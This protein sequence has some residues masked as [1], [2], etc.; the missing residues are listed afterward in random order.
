MCPL[1]HIFPEGLSKKDDS[2]E[3]P[4]DSGAMNII[5]TVMKIPVLAAILLSP[6]IVQAEV[7]DSYSGVRSSAMGGAHRGLGTSND[8]LFY[9]PAGMSSMARY[10]IDFGYSYNG[11]D[12]LTRTQLSIVDSKTSPVAGGVAYTHTRGNRDGQDVSLN[13]IHSGFSYRITPNFLLGATGKHYR[14]RYTNEDGKQEIAVYGGDIGML[15]NISP[16]IKFGVT[17]HNIVETDAAELTPPSV[18]GGLS[19]QF[20][21]L[22]A[23]A[24]IDYSLV[25]ETKGE[26]TYHGG[27]EYFAG[28][29]FALRAGYAQTKYLSDAGKSS[30]EGTVSGGAAYLTPTGA[31]T[32]SYKQS[33]QRSQRWDA[34]AAFKIFL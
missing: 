23:A 14:G 22:V 4:C 19:V 2:Y 21:S 29:A 10:N 11:G 6:A 31:L 26:M 13:Y 25:K 32:I 30:D 33:I 12:G 1:L 17:Y 18:A 15:L 5:A 24:D 7:A 27:V 9:N 20:G 3:N 28:G 16:L 34:V 8:T